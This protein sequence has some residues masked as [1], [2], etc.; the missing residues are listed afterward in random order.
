MKKHIKEFVVLI[1]QLFIFF[2]FPLFAG[3]GDE[4][5]MVVLI[6]L[7]TFVLSL[8]LGIISANKTKFLYPLAISL[9]FIPSV[10]V[11]YNSS[12]LVHA[13]WYLVISSAGLITGTIPR[14]IFTKSKQK[15]D[16]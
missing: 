16:K 12:A 2:I 15:S 3:P 14:I 6:I 5:G 9:L 1:L 11:Y 7:A 4:M 8:I 10:F 13:L